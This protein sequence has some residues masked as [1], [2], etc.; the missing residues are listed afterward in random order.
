[1]PPSAQQLRQVLY[2]VD[3]AFVQRRL[4]GTQDHKASPVAGNIELGSRVVSGP[5]P[6]QVEESHWRTDAQRRLGL[7]GQRPDTLV[8]FDED[9]ASGRTPA[10]GVDA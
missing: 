5:F 8:L 7:D 3:A 2:E 10:C 9:L 6:R 4:D 1:M